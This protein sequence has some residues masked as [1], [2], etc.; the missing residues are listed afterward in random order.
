MR[1]TFSAPVPFLLGGIVLLLL[2]GFFSQYVSYHPSTAVSLPFLRE[3]ALPVYSVE[4]EQKLAALSFDAAWGDEFT[5]EILE[6][7][8]RRGVH[9]TFFMTGGWVE[10]YPEDVK[11]IAE[12]GHDLGNHSQNHKQMSQLSET[13][14]RREIQSV[15]DQVKELTGKDMTLFRAPYGDYNDT[16]VHTAR[17]MGYQIVQWN[18]DSLDWKDYGADAIVQTV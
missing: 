15:H 18:I 9:A 6:I 12:L 17:D 11:R 2:A 4:T 8:E 7:L 3:R 14:I 5:S 10:A 16:L 13:E 1:K